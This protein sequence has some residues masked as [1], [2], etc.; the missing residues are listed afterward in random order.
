MTN[1]GKSMTSIRMTGTSMSDKEAKAFLDWYVESIKTDKQLIGKTLVLLKA[2]LAGVQEGLNLASQQT[3]D[4]YPWVFRFSKNRYA[5][6]D[7]LLDDDWD[8][9]PRADH[10]YATDPRLYPDWKA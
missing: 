1:F 6:K 10:N 9:A 3:L 5:H 7:P 2:F 8:F 4:P